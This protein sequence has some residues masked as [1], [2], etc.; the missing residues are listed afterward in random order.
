MLNVRMM[1]TALIKC[2]TRRISSYVP[3][4]ERLCPWR[5]DCMLPA[6]TS[7]LHNKQ[8]LI[9]RSLFDYRAMHFS[10]KRGIAIVCCPSVRLS[11]CV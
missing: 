10:A 7:N 2:I 9:I 6:C 3:R 4:L 5:H 1:L 11:V 8:S